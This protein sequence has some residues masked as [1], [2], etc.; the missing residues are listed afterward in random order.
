MSRISN[1][2]K[3]TT[4]PKKKIGRPLTPL[5]I[6]KK[7][8]VGMTYV[9]KNTNTGEY[10]RASTPCNRDVIR[11]EKIDKIRKLSGKEPYFLLK[12]GSYKTKLNIVKIL[13]G[14]HHA[15]PLSPDGVYEWLNMSVKEARKNKISFLQ[16]GYVNAESQVAEPRVKRKYTKR[17]KVVV[18]ATTE[19]P[20]PVVTATEV[21]VNETPVVEEVVVPVV[22]KVEQTDAEFAA[23]L[24]SEF[25]SATAGAKEI[26]AEAT[27]SAQ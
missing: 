8:G 6:K 23:E 26:L 20:S 12:I 19:V 13:C 22:A 16:P 27:S 1:K 25:Q 7:P 18:E 11:G 24:E 4:S 3:K 15:K 9:I 5:N 10:V 14:A 21:A 17:V 2:E